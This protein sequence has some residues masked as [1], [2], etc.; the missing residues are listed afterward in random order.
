MDNNEKLQKIIGIMDEYACEEGRLLAHQIMAEGH[1]DEFTAY[2]KVSRMTPV[3]YIGVNQT[4]SSFMEYLAILGVTPQL[5]YTI[6]HE[7]YDRA[8]QIAEGKGFVA[9]GL[10]ANVWDCYWC[11]CMMIADY[12]V[13]HDGDLDTAAMLAYQYLSDPDRKH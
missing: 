5:A 8:K 10:D 2:T 11:L 1:E 6:I 12:W 9:P 13:T 3:A 7:A 4:P